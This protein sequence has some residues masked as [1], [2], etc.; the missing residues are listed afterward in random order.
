LGGGGQQSAAN[1]LV[2]PIANAVADKLGLSPEIAMVAVSL[3]LNKL[4]SALSGGREA[5]PAQAAATQPGGFDLNQLLGQFGGG[6]SVDAD[7]LRSS[8][9]MDEMTEQ[10]GVDEETAEASLRE[11]FAVLGSQAGEGSPD[12]DLGSAEGGLDDLLG[13]W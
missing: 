9:L 7:F 11:V 2:Q 6:R 3:V 1:P 4:L 12:L 13:S 5:A 8:G 10:A